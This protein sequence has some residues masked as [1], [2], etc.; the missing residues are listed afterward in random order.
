MKPTS[1]NRMSLDLKNK[2]ASPCWSDECNGC[3]KQPATPNH[4]KRYLKTSN[5]G[6][7]NLPIIAITPQNAFVQDIATP[8]TAASQK[9]VG[10]HMSGWWNAAATVRRMMNEALTIGNIKKKKTKIQIAQVW[11][12]G[13]HWNEQKTVKQIQMM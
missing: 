12:T 13:G 11:V 2:T 9:Q 3:D 6:M 7:Q 5:N 10:Y 1:A 4:F 8:S